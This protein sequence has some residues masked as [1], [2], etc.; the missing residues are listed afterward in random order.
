M[1]INEKYAC[2]K[3]FEAGDRIVLCGYTGTITKISAD[4][5]ED[6]DT[7][8]KGMRFQQV[9]VALDPSVD[10]IEKTAYNNSVYGTFGMGFIGK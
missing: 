6:R 4:W 10:H 3:Q 2:G 7:Q 9:E 1:K 5:E 8:Y